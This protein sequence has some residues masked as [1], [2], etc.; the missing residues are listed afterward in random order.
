MS[1]KGFVSGVAALP[2]L[3][4]FGGVGLLAWRIGDSWDARATDTLISGLTA[5]CA[6]GAVVLAL[7]LGLIV[8]IP[9]LIRL[10]ASQPP[11]RGWG[12]AP[13]YR[14]L[15]GPGA[16]WASGPPMLPDKQQQGQWLSSG[17]AS[18][19]LIEVDRD[20]PEGW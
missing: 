2:V 3:A 4:L 1:W 13:S 15:P 16:S 20:A 9:L 7:L 5:S 17:P 19:D 6:G 18:Y 8:G 11:P 10:Q 12:D 14:A